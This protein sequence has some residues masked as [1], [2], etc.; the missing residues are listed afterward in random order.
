[1]AS[2]MRRELL[3][4]EMPD[5]DSKPSF[6]ECTS[7]CEI[8]SEYVDDDY[9]DCAECEDEAPN[10]TCETCDA[11][12]PTECDGYTQCVS[13]ESDVPFVCAS[14]CEIV[15]DFVND[16]HCDCAECEDE[17]DYTCETCDD[18]CPIECGES[19][20]CGEKGRK[21]FV[22]GKGRGSHNATGKVKKGAIGV[23]RRGFGRGRGQGSSSTSKH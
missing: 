5:F 18:G 16:N 8:S 9:C 14:G 15:A 22:K 1:L 17:P 6:F 7:G 11:G 21:L 13:D 3:S 2:N 19:R 10:Y 4:G 12:C 20:Q 23:S